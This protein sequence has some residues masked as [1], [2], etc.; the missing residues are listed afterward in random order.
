MRSYKDEWINWGIVTG[1][2]SLLM[3][4]H[5]HYSSQ[6]ILLVARAYGVEESLLHR[7]SYVPAA[8]EEI[9]ESHP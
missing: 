4:N 6:E 1:L 9:E 5:P 7:L 8:V 3:M 2:Q